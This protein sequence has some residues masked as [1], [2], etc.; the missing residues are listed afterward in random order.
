[1]IEKYFILFQ[2]TVKPVLTATSEQRPPVNN[3]QPD[4]QTSQTNCSFIGENSE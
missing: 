3:G 4:P 2:Y 1:M